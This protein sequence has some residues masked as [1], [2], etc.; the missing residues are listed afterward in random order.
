MS[1]WHQLT[2]SAHTPARHR[3]KR[4]AWG[5]VVLC[6]A[7]GLGLLMAP[8]A[9]A[10]SQAPDLPTYTGWLR[11]AYAA[12]Q[13][14]DRL[15]LED[16]ATRLEAATS[17]RLPDGTD[18]PTD[19]RWLREAL[20]APAPDLSVIGARL[21]A[22][23]DALALPASAA[24]ADARERL[25]AILAKPPFANSISDTPSW[26]S[27]FFDWLGRIL[28]SLFRP[29]GRVVAATGE[30]VAWVFA[31][32]GALLL[33]LVIGYVLR[34]LRRNVARGVDAPDD[35]EAHLTAHSALEQ[36]S[37]LARGGDYR[38]AVRYLYLSALLRLDERNI[39][40]Y[41]RALTNREYLERVRENPTLR[42]QLG[43][44]VET[45]DRVWYGHLP[46]DATA[47][48]AYERQVEA[49]RSEG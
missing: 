15:G 5:I 4:K 43:A 42:A 19:N 2:M 21:G 49:L 36:A 44:V 1:I 13:R 32:G 34:G 41:D 3:P 33:L 23:L 40:R 28:E 11:E 14:G 38:T 6:F 18:V 7:L 30:P 10:Q 16:A 25:R 39:L 47:F 27:T 29:V 48:A 12:A 26:V 37:G 31:I 9:Q 24:P 20:A 22:I 35:P 45:F 17:V 46:I 8:Q